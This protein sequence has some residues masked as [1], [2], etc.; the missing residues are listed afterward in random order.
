VIT[1]DFNIHMHIVDDA[2]AIKLRGLLEST[3]LKQHVALSTHI[4]KHTLD[5]IITRLSDK[6]AVSTPWTDYLF[7]HHMPVPCKFKLNKLAF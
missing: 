5:L 4:S 7:S 1:G 2:N 3:G 6:L